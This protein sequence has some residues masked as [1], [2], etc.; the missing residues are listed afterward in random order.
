MKYH[1]P[2]RESDIRAISRYIRVHGLTGDACHPTAEV[3]AWEAAW[4]EDDPCVRAQ[5]RAD[6]QTT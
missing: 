3:L 1:G 4:E 6:R 2:T 5:L